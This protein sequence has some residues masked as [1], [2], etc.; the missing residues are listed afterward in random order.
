MSSELRV[1][2]ERLNPICRRAL[3]TAAALCVAQT[4]YNV[5]VEHLLLK[6]I[7]LPA[8]DVSLVLRYYGV[9]PND[10]AQQLT[11]AIEKFD[12][13]NSRTPAM[14]PQILRLLREGWVTSSLLLEG[15]AIRSGALLFALYED[16]ALRTT[17][18]ESCPLLAKIQRESLRE[19]LRD[20]IRDSAEE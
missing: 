2:I 5:E 13:G 7:D 17:I 11:A 12:R 14:S 3:E 15:Q 9:E 4:H 20:L 10:L 1:L 18:H 8:T 6:L 16:D 19:T